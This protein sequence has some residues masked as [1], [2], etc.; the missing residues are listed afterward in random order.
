MCR[1]QTL[2]DQYRKK[3][4]TFSD[5]CASG[6]T[7]RWFPLHWSCWMGPTVWKL[8]E[9]LW[10]HEFSPWASCP[11]LASLDRLQCFLQWP[12][13]SLGIF[14]AVIVYFSYVSSVASLCRPSWTISDYFEALRKS[15]GMDPVG[16]NVGQLA[17]P[18]LSGDFFTYADRDDHYWSGYFTSR[19]FYKRW[20]ECWNHT[21]G[22]P[23]TNPN[24]LRE[25]LQWHLPSA[26]WR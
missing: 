9:T 22:K 11:G 3:S 15:T 20:T 5:Q 7:W 4:Q 2:L 16:M 12:T 6:T 1:V 26:K 23:L 10:L 21:S 8:P 18:V 17:L 24:A 13:W 14:S 25:S 19:P